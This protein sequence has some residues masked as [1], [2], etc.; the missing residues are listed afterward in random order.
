MSDRRLD[1][2]I[3]SGRARAPDCTV[4]LLP[5]DDGQYVNHA[6]D[7][8]ALLEES[9]VSVD[10]ATDPVAAG[11]HAEKSADLVLP[12]LLILFSDAA[13]LAGAIEGVIYVIRWFIGTR[14]HR[15]VMVEVTLQEDADGST[16]RTLT[17]DAEGATVDEVARLLKQ[18]GGTWKAR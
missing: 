16:R 15:H 1:E 5:R 3:R 18:A 17:L 8:L 13:T 2:L 11:I 7:V 10:Y 9:G 14:N 6:S 4:Y 12:P